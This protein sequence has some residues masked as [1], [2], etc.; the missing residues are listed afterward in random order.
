MSEMARRERITVELPPDTVLDPSQMYLYLPASDPKRRHYRRC[1]RRLVEAPLAPDAGP[2]EIVGARLVEAVRTINVLPVARGP[3]AFGNAWPAV[4]RKVTT[5]RRSMSVE[6]WI[7]ALTEAGAVDA[8]RDEQRWA[9]SR[10]RGSPTPDAISRAYEAMCW[11]A[12]FLTGRTYWRHIDGRVVAAEPKPDIIMRVRAGG[13]RRERVNLWAPVKCDAEGLARIL[14]AWVISKARGRG[15]DHS[16]KKLCRQNGWAYST[17]RRKR[18]Q[19]L[20]IIAAGL[21][22]EGKR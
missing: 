5:P 14:R 16:I 1:R 11:P 3:K 10:S 13:M 8:L 22:A 4:V 21:A 7:E 18:Q 20:E 19:A 6:E 2:A 12:R 17:F 15:D 9:W